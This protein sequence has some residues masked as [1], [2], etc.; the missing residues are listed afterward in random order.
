MAKNLAKIAHATD[1][2]LEEKVRA[3]RVKLWDQRREAEL[4]LQNVDFTE[5]IESVYAEYGDVS[6]NMPALATLVLQRLNARPDNYRLLADKA[7]TFIR[8]ADWLMVTK[9]K[10]GGVKNKRAGHPVGKFGA[11]CNSRII[12]P[13]THSRKTKKAK[14]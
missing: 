8:N 7:M 3:F 10:G 14:R 1:S 2:Q 12:Y 6:I 4:L 9:G 5:A 13:T 11:T